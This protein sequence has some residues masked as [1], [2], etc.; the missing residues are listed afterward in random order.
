MTHRVNPYVTDDE[1]NQ[2]IQIESAGKPLAKASTSSATGLG[3][4]LGQTWLGVVNNHG[5]K[6]LA[7]R[8]VK[9]GAKWVVPDG[10]EREILDLRKGTTRERCKFMVD[11]LGHFTADSA[12]ALGPGRTNGDLYLAHFLGLGAARKVMRASLNDPVEP[13]VGAAAVEANERIL[14]GKTCGQVRAWASNAMNTRWEKAGK[15]DWVAV[16]WY[17][18]E[19]TGAQLLDGTDSSERD[20]HPPVKIEPEPSPQLPV[21]H[22]QRSIEIREI[23]GRLDKMGYHPGEIDGLWGGRTAG[24]IAAFKN[25]RHVPGPPQIDDVLKAELTE[26][27]QN[28]WRRPIAPE[29]KNATEAQL[30]KKLPEVGAAKTSE[31]TAWWASI[32]TLLTSLVTGTASML[33]DATGY[34]TPVKAL[35]T[36]VPGWAWAVLGIALAVSLWYAS[37]KSAD[38]ATSATVAYQEGARV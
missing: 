19:L 4:F 33:G 2:T 13:I 5:P 17:P 30:E 27:E 32:F 25:D 11:M 38:A 8:I 1:L 22:N 36:E 7:S 10:G 9:R 28:N 20:D 18:G 23:Q 34:L 6:D 37:K 31:R 24:A 29:R 26:A 15:K 16:Y 12:R 14:R 21:P 35:A 3:Q